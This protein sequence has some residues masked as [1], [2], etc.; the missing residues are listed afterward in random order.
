VFLIP[1]TQ[2]FQ[3]SGV[4]V[5]SIAATR[6]HRSLIEF[7]GYYASCLFRS[8]VLMIITAEIAV[9]SIPTRLRVIGTQGESRHQ[10]DFRSATSA[11]QGRSGRAHVLRGLS[12]F[13][14]LGPICIVYSIKPVKETP[15]ASAKPRERFPEMMGSRL[16]W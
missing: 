2:M 15:P 1:I 4:V 8:S 10:T 3:L 5:M 14:E 16:W 12:S 9:L 6:M 13:P 11:R 7:T